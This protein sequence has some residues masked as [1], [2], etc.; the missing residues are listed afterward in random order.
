[1]PEMQA[2]YLYPGPLVHQNRS[3]IFAARKS[4]FVK[5]IKEWVWIKF[6]HGMYT[7]SIPLSCQ[8]HERTTHGRNTC[9]IADS[10]TFHFF[11]TFL[12]VTYIVNVIGFFFSVF[13]SGK[14]AP[15]IRLAMGT[16]S[17]TCRI[18]EQFF[19]ELHWNN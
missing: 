16:R 3:M 7:R 12:M 15:D 9:G 14:D 2:A 1:M 13:G 19:E 6:F 17:K 11:V 10:L 8:E 5:G 18:R 4:I